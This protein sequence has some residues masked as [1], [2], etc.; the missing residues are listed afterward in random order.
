MIS[1]NK[2]KY[3]IGDIIY[4]GIVPKNYNVWIYTALVFVKKSLI[5]DFSYFCVETVFIDFI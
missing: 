2:T 4:L 1:S 3:F 5:L